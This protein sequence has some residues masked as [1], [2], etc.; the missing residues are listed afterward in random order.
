M[1]FDPPKVLPRSPLKSIDGGETSL[2]GAMS[3]GPGLLVIGHSECMTTRLV[4]PFVDR[5]Y[6]RAP[7]GVRVVAVLQDEPAAA[8]GLGSELG[9][10][11]PLLLDAE[12]YLL[13][14]ALGLETVPTLL[15][16]A[17]GRRVEAVSQGFRRSELEGFGDRLGVAGPLFHE[18]DRVPA[19]QPG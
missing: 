19:L 1:V 15:L 16:V 17:P 11:L 9:L 13:G 14:E 3:H 12:P 5:I 4:L 10:E 6:R 7:E 18:T 8:A 2:D